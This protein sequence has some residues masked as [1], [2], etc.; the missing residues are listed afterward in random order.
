MERGRASAGYDVGS[1]SGVP[2]RL[3]VNLP[4]CTNCLEISLANHLET[5][6]PDTY[7]EPLSGKENIQN[8]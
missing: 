4:I 3:S 7:C 1:D 2:G 6:G 8:A 5:L